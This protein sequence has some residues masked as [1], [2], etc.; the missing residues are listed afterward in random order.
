[1]IKTGTDITGILL[2]GGMSSRMGREKGLVRLGD[3]Y[4]YQ[5]PLQVLQSLCDEILISTCV[6]LPIPETHSRVCDEIPG[7]GPMGGIYTCLKRSSNETSIVISYDLPM[8][9]EGLFRYLLAG[10]SGHDAVFPALRP[11]RPEP[12]CAVFKKSMIPVL[13][14][15]IVK[16]EFAV[17]KVIPLARSRIMPVGAHLTFYHPDIFIN[18]NREEDMDRLPPGFG[19]RKPGVHDQA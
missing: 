7:L 8:V 19:R 17:H 2:A 13:E 15:L 3:R 5:Y 1:M 10:S 16:G 9:S 18:I 6:D 14:K 4:L 11:D 12:L